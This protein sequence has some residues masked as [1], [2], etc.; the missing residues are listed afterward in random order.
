M[1]FAKWFDEQE[2]IVKILLLIPFWG[3][4]IGAVYRVFKYIET[5][6]TMTLVGAILTF[7]PFIGFFISIFDLVTVIMSGEVKL[8]I[9]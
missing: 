6:E 2:K 7:I 3:W 4:A 9:K 8:F 5:K 1:G